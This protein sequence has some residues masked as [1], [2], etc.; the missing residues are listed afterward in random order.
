M[1][2]GRALSP[3]RLRRPVYVN[4]RVPGLLERRPAPACHGRP[5]GRGSAF[6]CLRESV[7][8]EFSP[9]YRR[10]LGAVFTAG[11]RPDRAGRNEIRRACGWRFDIGEHLRN[12]CAESAMAALESVGYR[13]ASNPDLRSF[14]LLEP[15]SMPARPIVPLAGDIVAAAAPWSGYDDVREFGLQGATHCERRGY[16]I[17]NKA[18]GWHVS[19]DVD[20]GCERS[21]S[22]GNGGPA[23]IGYLDSRHLKFTGQAGRLRV[24]SWIATPCAN[25]GFDWIRPGLVWSW[26]PAADGSDFIDWQQAEKPA[27]HWHKRRAARMAAAA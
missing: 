20:S 14:E 8:M 4:R 2:S 26:N 11:Y 19:V 12:S 22:M 24:W 25:G 21:L 13:L 27:W 18:G 3:L 6:D 1:L 16:T 23:S 9:V 15:A 17:A 5:A 7:V 10:A